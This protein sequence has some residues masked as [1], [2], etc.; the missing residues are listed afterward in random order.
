MH[1]AIL[2]WLSWTAQEEKL[3][4]LSKNGGASGLGRPADQADPADADSHE[5]PART[6]C[7]GRYWFPAPLC[8]GRSLLPRRQGR[9]TLFALARPPCVR[10][11]GS[12]RRLPVA[13]HSE[14][15]TVPRC[16][17]PMPP[18]PRR[19]SSLVQRLNTL[20]RC[21]GAMVEG[22]HPSRAPVLRSA[23]PIAS[24]PPPKSSDSL[25]FRFRLYFV[26][27]TNTL[28]SASPSKRAAIP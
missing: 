5:R 12:S 4:R 24:Y 26:N 20:R 16:A 1:K 25:N 6:A 7:V 19:A 11:A 14:P 18:C 21:G 13:P 10:L 28:Q 27:A 23:R 3:K 9:P 22:Q 8:G 17:S 15:A 2:S